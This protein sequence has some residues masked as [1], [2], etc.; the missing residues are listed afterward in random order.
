MGGGDFGYQFGRQMKLLGGRWI[1]LDKA[2][3]GKGEAAVERV[4][5]DA[6]KD[7]NKVLDTPGDAVKDVTSAARDI[8]VALSDDLGGALKGIEMPLLI[9]GA[10]IL[11]IL[12]LK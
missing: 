12:V 2:F 10:V 3:L 11:A 7:V 6:D 1:A 4:Y 8:G 5:T 9:G